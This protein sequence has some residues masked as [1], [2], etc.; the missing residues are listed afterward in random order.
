MKLLAIETSSA[1]GSLALLDGTAVSEREIATPREQ[2]ENVLPIVRELVAEA[3]LTLGSLDAIAFGRGPGSFSGI[4]LAA[5]VAQGLALS[6]GFPVIAV[7]S[8]AAAAQRAWREHGSS[9]SLVCVDARMGE[10]YWAPFC[11]DD[12]LAE[13]D[14]SERLGAPA[15][16]QCPTG[17]PWV[18][19]GNGFVEYRDELAAQLE[20]AAAVHDACLP[21]ARD[22]LPRASRDCAAGRVSPAAAALPVYLRDESAWRRSPSSP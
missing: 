3:G 22:L 15:T 1:V 19:V 6:S 13:H 21:T 5:A 10:V 7:S 16:L 12:G 18:A 14:G 20:Q 4:R 17:D 8:L 2:S 9:R 11:I